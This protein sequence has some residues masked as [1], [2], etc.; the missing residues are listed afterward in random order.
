LRTRGGRFVAEG[1]MTGRLW[2]GIGIFLLW[3]V[4]AVVAARALF[5]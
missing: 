3:L 1:C 4:F 5:T 2:P